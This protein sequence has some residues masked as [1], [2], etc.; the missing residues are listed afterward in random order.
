MVIQ[1]MTQ[2]TQFLKQK[3]WI[4]PDPPDQDAIRAADE[5][6]RTLRLHPVI[7][8]LL[9]A[10][11]YHTPQD[12]RRFLTMADEML[13]DPFSLADIIPA[14]TRIINAV[15]TGEKITIWGDYDVD[16]VTSVCTLY[17]YLRSIGAKV[18]YYIPN[19]ATDG[20]G[21]SAGAVDTIARS[22]TTLI[23][24]V[25][26]GITANAEVESASSLGVDFVITD[27]HE[28]HAELPAACAVINPHRPDCPYPFKELAGVGVV[29]KLISAI[30][31]TRT[32]K[33]RAQVASRLFDLY[34]DF[35]AIGTIADVMPIRG[36]NRII[37]SRGLTL[38]EKNVRV[39]LLALMDA[40]SVGSET[41]HERRKARKAKISSAYIGYTI[42]PRINAAGR[43]RS[44]G[45]AVE[46]FLSESYGRAYAI[47]E[48]LCEAN[49]ERQS[50]ENKIIAEAKEKI[51][52]AYDMT[53]NPVI[54]L[55]SD[56]WHHGVIGIV[57]SR[58]T[59]K[60]CRPSI[61]VSFEGTGDVPRREDVG[62][63]SGRSIRGLNL[64]DAL[65]HCG[66]Y[67]VKYGGH[68]LAAGLSVTRENLPAFREKIN[69]Y[70]RANLR[71]EDMIP[72]LDCDMEIPFDAVD[73]DL[74]EQLRILEP[75]GV[76]NAQPVFVMRG[77]AVTQISGVS[78]GKHTRI[79]FGDG[80]STV[81]AMFFS[82]APDTLGLC[83]GD[84]AD[85]V[86]TIDIN[87]WQGRRFV[88]MIVKDIRCSASQSETEDRERARFDE[89]WA[90]AP[91]EPGEDFVPD[92]ED[93]AAVYH[94][95][96]S[97]ARCGSDTM[98]HREIS[99]RLG[100]G[101]DAHPIGYVK[102]KVIIKVLIELNIVGIEEPKEEVYVFRLRYGGKTDLEKSSLLRR[103]RAQRRAAQ[104]GS[105]VLP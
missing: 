46:L 80:K 17:L 11:G 95:I 13:A 21:V 99:A 44:A 64:V 1:Y 85:V 47:A 16:G 96:L 52:D 41:H 53:E 77:V 58:I 4:L 23:I 37:V 39:G 60:Y 70:A 31:E 19:R 7:A 81:G 105:V 62:K 38:M 89:V 59:E 68:E 54:V 40:A 50:E 3:K 104:N 57:A 10:R 92:R 25:D 66:D 79:T 84:L 45:R 2:Q 61:L 49:R 74:A 93:F 83:I 67:L 103:L 86:F 76:G 36:E 82:H 69:E 20:Y 27:H 26:T 15:G 87:E 24:T 73:M 48:E 30:E 51:G 56:H 33:P 22:G 14:V 5:M 88:Q 43:I 90:G 75:Y 101:T 34:A 71:P 72:A 6:C 18:D 35:V 63:G 97:A 42:A 28:C 98:T 8:R 78:D 100:L 9:Y 65:C 32:G 102:L 91:I 29:F 94:L 55:D 12:A